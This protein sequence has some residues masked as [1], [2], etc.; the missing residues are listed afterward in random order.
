MDALRERHGPCAH[1]PGDATPWG[2]RAPLG[3]KH[4]RLV[5]L[6]AAGWSLSELCH[7]SLAIFFGLSRILAANDRSPS[8]VNGGLANRWVI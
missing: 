4:F 5:M 3:T 6:A 7:K 2:W 8:L 1:L